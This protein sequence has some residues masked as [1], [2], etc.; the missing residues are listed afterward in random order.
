MWPY[1]PFRLWPYIYI[2]R[3]RERENTKKEKKGKHTNVV[4]T[5]PIPPLRKEKTGP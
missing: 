2:Y 4:I 3:E 5:N 1:H